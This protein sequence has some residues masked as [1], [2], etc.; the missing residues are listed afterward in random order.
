MHD[1]DLYQRTISDTDPVWHNQYLM[2]RALARAFS[3]R[4]ND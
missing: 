3:A 1:C 4:E 2:L